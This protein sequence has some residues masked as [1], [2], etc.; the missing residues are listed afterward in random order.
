MKE[1]ARLR[2]KEKAQVRWRINVI[3]F[4]DRYGAKLTK[5]AYG[6]GRCIPK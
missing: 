1:F 2:E 4:F 3:G 5:E 6:V